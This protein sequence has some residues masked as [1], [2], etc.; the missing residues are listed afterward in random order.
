M[1][2]EVRFGLLGTFEL[3]VDGRPV[4]VR[5]PKVRIVLAALLLEPGRVV[6]A[7]ELIDALWGTRQ[8]D[9]PRRAL[10]VCLT[11]VR[12]SLLAAGA[13]QLIVAGADGYHADVPPDAVDVVRFRRWLERAD[14]VDD[15]AL[16]HDALAAA[17]EEWR[18]EPLADVPSDSLHR[19]YAVQLAEQRLE[20]F[21][22]WADLRLRSGQ[23]A[24]VV[25]KLAELTARHPLR[26]GLWALY[27]TALQHSGRRGDA[28]D[29]YHRVRQHLA[30]ELGIEPGEDLQRRYTAALEDAPG[31]D[32]GRRVVPRQLP[33]ALSGFAGRTGELDRMRRLLEE[34]QDGGSSVL[35]I[36]GMAGVGKS[37]LAAHWAR[38]VADR[39]PDGQLWLD[40]RGYDRRAPAT[41]LQS[42]G[43]ILRALGVRAAD[44]PADLDGR[45][46]LFRSVLDGRRML[47]VLDNAGG[48]DQ[49]LPLLPGDP[50]TMV[51]I[52]SRSDLTSL[53]AIEGARVIRL[54][55][56]TPAEARHMLEPRLGAERVRAEPDAV[57][58]IISN[59]AGLPLALAIVAA[60]AV[61]RPNFTLAAIDRQ[62]AEVGSPLD[63]F[64]DPGAALDVR[65]VFSWS[66]CSLSTPAARLFRLMGTQPAAELSVAAAAALAGTMGWR[67]RL[68]LDELAAAHLV[69]ERSPD[70]FAVH[71]L[72]RAYAVELAQVHDAPEQR[73]S[74][75]RRLVDWLTRTALNARPLLQPSETPVAPEEPEGA[76]PALSFDDERAAHAWYDS[77]RDLLV[78]AVD[79]AYAQ[80][81]DDLCWRLAY[82][83]WVR[84]HLTGAWDDLLRTHETGLRAAERL[85]DRIGQAQMLTGMGTAFRST[86]NPARAIH[87]HRIALELF[88]AA[89]DTN[90][91][92]AALS[93]LCAAHRDAGEFDEALRCG[94]LAYGLEEALDE[95]GNMAIA[96]FQIGMT[97]IAADR[98]D[99]AS[100]QIAE[101]LVIMRKL[102][103]RRAEARGLQLA[104]TADLRA[105]R[106]R[107]AI[108]HHR[109]ALDIYRELGDRE[110]EAAA[111]TE[112]GDALREDRRHTESRDAWTRALAI[113]D[114]LG[115]PVAADLRARLDQPVLPGTM[116]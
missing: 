75:L 49:V 17:L 89:S 105:G 62:L 3:R 81:F 96:L 100:P 22:R 43:V 33:A 98:P 46:G 82:G 48:V 94:R 91:I 70:R 67:V 65:A 113:Y 80:G 57:G 41:P 86:G 53:V 30:D 59:C 76:V 51:L 13:P 45:V 78:A 47:L 7:A 116:A 37:T 40:L 92:A 115:A 44:V 20:A 54:D 52:T 77:E 25:G 9:H 85:G 110:Y 18:D 19:G 28:L 103:H 58:R 72:L 99:E 69:V 106:H 56:F 32:A 87:L 101:A 93:N 15:P 95:P 107:V 102:G 64:A 12:A 109:L 97:L 61:R 112:L 11:R 35:V 42:V 83:I 2:V 108:D 68:L 90:G 38:R 8:P 21:E 84:L 114:A 66:Y 74:D 55:P 34:Q 111:L 29:A 26:E 1:S 60:R 16:A 73:A 39:F 4:L 24:S 6:P 23:P 14:A 88:R 27:V 50:R 71:D 5:S 31:A 63:R 104:A 79:L 10:H 36:T